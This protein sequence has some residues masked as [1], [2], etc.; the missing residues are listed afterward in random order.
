MASIVTGTL[1]KWGGVAKFGGK[2]LDAIL[3]MA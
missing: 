1:L 3:K 2:T